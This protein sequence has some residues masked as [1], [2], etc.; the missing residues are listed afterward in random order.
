MDKKTS[1]PIMVLD[2]TGIYIHLKANLFL[3]Y[4]LR[5]VTP[6]SYFNDAS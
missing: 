5:E 6:T 2:V 3:L 4:S 1:H